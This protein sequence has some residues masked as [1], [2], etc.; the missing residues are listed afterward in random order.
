V[1]DL[2]PIAESYVDDAVG[3]TPAEIRDLSPILHAP[4]T[5]VRVVLVVGADETAEF[6]RQSR[7]LASAWSEAAVELVELPGRDHFDLVDA[8]LAPDA[9]WLAGS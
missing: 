8:A 9:P 7:A 1:F 5:G 2:A 3:M 4:P 6:L